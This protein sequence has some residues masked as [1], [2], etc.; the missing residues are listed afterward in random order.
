ML[1]QRGGSIALKEKRNNCHLDSFVKLMV[2]RLNYY[3]PKMYTKYHVGSVLIVVVG[4]R[5]ILS[6]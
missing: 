5:T 6:F 4:I 1:C 3:V 2:I